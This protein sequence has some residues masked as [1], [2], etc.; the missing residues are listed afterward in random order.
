MQ[1]LLLCA[2]LVCGG[3]VQAQQ[4]QQLTAAHIPS[5]I[6][7]LTLAEKVKLVVGAGMNFNINSQQATVGQTAEKV[8]GAAGTSQAIARLGIPK[9][10][11]A[12]GPAGVRISPEREQFPDQSFYATAFPV[13]TLMAAS[14]NEDLMQAVGNAFGNETKAYGVDILLAPALNIHRNPLGGRNFEYYSEDPVLSG[15]MAAAF[16]KGVQ[17]QGVG[18]SI[19]H[20]AANNQETN[21]TQINAI[22]SQRALRELYLKGFEIA[23]KEAHPWTVMSAYNKI[24]GVYASESHDLLTTILRDEWG[25]QGFVMTDWFAGRN[26]AAQMA[27]GNDLLMP[28]TPEQES[29]IMAAVK[30]GT[31]KESVLDQNV[32][33]ILDIY[34]KTPTFKNETP[35]NKPDLEGHK[36][37]A[38]QAA[39]EGM[40]L[41]K[42][43]R[44]TLPFTST[45]RIALLGNGAYA[46]IAGGTGSGD[47]NKAYAVSIAQGLEAKGCKLSAEIKDAYVT[48]IA[49]EREKAGPKEF[50]FEPD[51]R[52]PE[53]DWTT[54]EIQA[55][56]THHDLAVFTITR[57]SGEFYDRK[58]EA[59]FELT[60]RE[61]ALLNKL[62]NAFHSQDK[63]LVVLLN[64]GGVI[65]TGSWKNEADAI[66]VVWQPGQEGGHAVASVLTGEVNPSGKLPMTF[67]FTYQDVLA[68]KNFPGKE[69]ETVTQ[70]NPF[71]GVKSEVVYEEDIYIGYRYFNT[72]NKPVSF[73]F[74]YGLSY[75]TFTYKDIKNEP[76]ENGDL[77]VSL[78][79]A[80]T[81]QQAGKEVVQLYVA[82]PKG[83][84]AKPQLEL[85]AFAKTRLLTPGETQQLQFTLTPYQL[86]SFDPQA[87]AWVMEAGN[88][89][90]MAAASATRQPL[91]V[92][93]TQP[94]TIT[95]LKTN[96]VLAPEKEITDAA[97]TG[98][99]GN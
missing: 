31:L 83:K 99:K 40:V 59:D 49:A 29:Q 51:K 39:A 19:K 74:G 57:T 24:N 91:T 95:T 64:I 34:V 66:V 63:K 15:K 47:V 46:T 36:K 93:F 89:F 85:K 3:Y 88:Y 72:F 44:A 11:F 35:T 65:E 48:H 58:L 98:V 8:P 90:I 23:V 9:V 22:V 53:K 7:K 86:S 94:T 28:G 79:V 62:A 5:I 70:V 67:P 45:T 87:S 43:D 27:A 41:L 73:P 10:V 84:L 2:L 18:T 68:S 77:T 4:T 13:A 17:S 81:G 54:Q 42:N 21:R 33:A 37:I 20:F 25:Y 16:V 75:T 61:T 38:A 32:A 6:Q 52:I 92:L 60:S 12:D 71:V 78:T 14:F 82:A 69:L 30:E 55:M 56:A 26:P 97:P 50:F 1:K 96:D 76:Q 80:N